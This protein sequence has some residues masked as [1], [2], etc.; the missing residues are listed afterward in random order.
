MARILHVLPAFLPATAWGGPVV[1]T[2]ALCRAAAGGG[3]EVAVLTTDAAA[4]DGPARLTPGAIAAAAPEGYSV[5]HARRAFGRSGSWEMLARLPGMVARADLVHLSMSYSFPTLPTLLLCRLLGRPVVWSPRGAIQATEDWPGAPRRRLKTAFEAVARRLLPR[6]AVLHVTSDAE[7]RATA[8]RIP[9]VEVAVIANAVAVPPAPPARAFR[10]GGALRL[11]F[12]GRLHPKKGVEALLDALAGLP[13]HVTLAIAG[14][15]APAY[16]ATLAARAA[17]L[18]L[19][20]RVRFLGQCDGAA[21]LRALAE[22]DAFVLP[23]QSE[24]FGIAIAEALAAGLPVITTTAAPW[25]GLAT[26]GCGWWIAPEPA[27]L[28]IALRDLDARPGEILAEMGRRGHAW[29]AAAFSEPAVG[30]QVLDL[31]TRVLGGATPAPA[32]GVAERKAI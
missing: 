3:H 26:Q 11:L 7:A 25:A 5:V 10:P 30:A 8:R 1:S 17:R 2:A 31:Y 23:T 18:G 32:Q 6:R 22:A 24:N 15:G 13:G 4:P 28:P 9:G 21:K 20:G 14:Q 12:L 19:D 29:M 27:E 16:E